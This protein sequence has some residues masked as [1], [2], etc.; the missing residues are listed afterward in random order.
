M[1]QP[2]DGR[3]KYLVVNA[4]EGKI[5]QLDTFEILGKFLNN[6]DL[7]SFVCFFNDRRAWHL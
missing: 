4:D 5:N 1:N 6:D 2:D 3:P 7:T